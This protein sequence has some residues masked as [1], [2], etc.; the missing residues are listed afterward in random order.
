M[1]NVY[2]EHATS[3]FV[4]DD[5]DYAPYR[6]QDWT[7]L[8]IV[9]S[10]EHINEYVFEDLERNDYVT[11][12]YIFC[13]EGMSHVRELPD[14]SEEDDS[15]YMETDHKR[16]IR[17]PSISSETSI[18][19][20]STVI[21]NY[22]N[23]KC[24]TEENLLKLSKSKS[25]ETVK[26]ASQLNMKIGNNEVSH[27][28]T[29]AGTTRRTFHQ[30][31]EAVKISR[32]QIIEKV[33]VHQ[34]LTYLHACIDQSEIER[35]R[36]ISQNDNRKAAEELLEL[37]QSSDEP[38][39][40]QLLIEALEETGH[41]AAVR[42]LK[43]ESIADTKRELRI[44]H[45][46]APRLREM[47]VPHEIIP[48]LKAFDLITPMD[49]EEIMAKERQFGNVYATDHLLQCIPKKHPDWYKRF[50]EAVADRPE[51][52][53]I[54]EPDHATSNTVNRKPYCPDGKA[55]NSYKRC[56]DQKAAEG[57]PRVVRPFNK[58]KTEQMPILADVDNSVDTGRQCDDLDKKANKHPTCHK[59][60]H[61]D[62]GEEQRQKSVDKMKFGEEELE[63][64]EKE[65]KDLEKDCEIQDRKNALLRKKKD[66]KEELEKKKN[67]GEALQKALSRDAV[68]AQV[69]QSSATDQNLSMYSY[70][71]SQLSLNYRNKTERHV[72]DERYEA[73][74]TFGS[75]EIG[76]QYLLASQ[77]AT[78]AVHDLDLL[79]PRVPHRR[80]VL[81][82]SFSQ[83]RFD[84]LRLYDVDSTYQDSAFYSDLGN[85]AGSI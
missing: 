42:I 36:L 14:S 58:H 43:Q 82:P 40:W 2:T 45:M 26:Y 15:E 68:H 49:E 65:I 1:D 62:V 31:E 24:T 59:N 60:F 37:I 6:V 76:L 23:I 38:G 70:A 35:I 17:M 30:I 77:T 75:H 79:Y 29:L 18:C 61:D 10:S 25:A 8:Q 3:A 80:C 63:L 81:L 46:V 9:E 56:G 12:D 32:A 22:F 33:M 74:S 83:N 39:K 28:R 20:S 7:K 73:A 47:I 5:L 85:S 21:K 19:E 69:K 48:A 27:N 57:E 51:L 78:G 53:E 52:L 72:V 13:G 67:E 41:Q 4:E 50:L 44:L 66:L 34:I 71:N 16:Y 64:L 84:L 55:C 54:I 11:S